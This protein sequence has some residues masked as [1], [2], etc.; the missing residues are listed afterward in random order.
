MVGRALAL[1]NGDAR[2]FERH[3]ARELKRWLLTVPAGV[4]FATLISWLKLLVGFG[5]SGSG[6]FSAGNG[7]AMRSALIGVCVESDDALVEAVR[8]STRVTHTDPK[9]EEGALLIARAARLAQTGANLGPRELISSAAASVA[10]NELRMIL[11]SVVDALAVGMS[12]ADFAKSQGWSRGISGYVN[13]TVPAALYCWAHSPDDFRQCV[14]NAVLLGGDSDSVAAITGAICGANLGSDAI[15]SEWVECLAE[16][17][18]T[19][20]WIRSLAKELAAALE[21]GKVTDPPPMYWM[22]TFP[23]NALFTAVVI[24]LGFRRLFPPY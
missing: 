12:C 24:L 22:A 19:T 21:N 5:P 1:S 8:A 6:V 11:L 20:D 10:G 9:A 16:W 2:Q 13:Q 18:R 4:G 15:P 7:P 14:E 3:F 17:P 23:R